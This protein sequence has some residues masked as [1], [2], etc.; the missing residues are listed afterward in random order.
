MNCPYYVKHGK[1]YITCR[2]GLQDVK[3]QGDLKIHIDKACNDKYTVCR[4]Y[5]YLERSWG[6][7]QVK[8]CTKND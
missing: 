3:Y 8:I 1:L 5:K 6:S 4:C 2:R 7:E